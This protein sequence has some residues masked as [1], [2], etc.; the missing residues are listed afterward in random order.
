MQNKKEKLERTAFLWNE[1]NNI[2][3]VLKLLS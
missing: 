1:V 3:W 2:V